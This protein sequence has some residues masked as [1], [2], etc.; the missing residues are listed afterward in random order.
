MFWGKN[1]RASR[2]GRTQGG[3]PHGGDGV[4]ASDKHDLSKEEGRGHEPDRQGLEFPS[5]LFV[6]V[7]AEG[8]GSLG[9]SVLPVL[10]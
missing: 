5:L 9:F 2:L 4:D 10:G 6:I 8:E 7:L 1:K 3:S